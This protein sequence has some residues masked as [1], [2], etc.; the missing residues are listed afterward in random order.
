MLKH[1][2][3][4]S[5][6]A[7]LA[8]WSAAAMVVVVIAVTSFTLWVLRSDMT[9][10]VADV[11]STLSESI[12]R[13]VDARVADRRLALQQAASVLDPAMIAKPDELREHF[14]SRPVVQGLFET[15]IVVD[16][17]GRITFDTPSFTGR[18]GRSVADRPYFK[19]LMAT[20]RPVVSDPLSGRATGE[21]SIVFA[22]PIRTATGETVGFLGGVMYLTR[23]NFLSDLANVK[24][25]KTGYVSVIV[26][27]DPPVIMMHG[28]KDRIMTPVPPP[29]S[30]PLVYRALAGD[31]GSFEGTNSVGL[32]AI[33]SFRLL[34][35]VPWL[36]TTA[37]PLAEA[38]EQ[39]RGSERQV[40]ALGLG[41]M[42]LAGIGIWVLVE[43]LL[44][45]LD[46]LRAAMVQSRDRSEPV[47]VDVRDE[48]REVYEVVEAYNT[49]MAH[50]HE[51]RAAV[52]QSEQRL[53]TI[54]DNLPVLIS[55][56]DAD[57]RM[58]FA[59]ETY[60][61]WSDVD[62]V[63]AIGRRIAD[64]VAPELY[65]QR[66]D[67]LRAALSGQRVEFDLV[68][69]ARGARRHLHTVYVPDVRED[70]R[71]AGLY[72]LSTDVT[73]LKDVE[74]KLNA[75]ARVD[76]LTGLPNRRAFD[77]RLQASVAR[78]R[79]TRQRLALLFLDV[80]HFKEINDTRGHG[81][82]DEVLCEFA[83][84]LLTCVRQTDTV[85]RLA[86]DE[87]V[88]ILEGLKDLEEASAIAEK[89]GLLM[90]LP[91]HVGNEI[92]RVTTSIGV[93][94]VDDPRIQADDIMAKADGALYR[95]KRN[96]RNTFAVST[97]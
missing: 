21:A 43:R 40:I 55:Y 27:G 24:V 74:T 9:R 8:F 32:D 2:K 87:F 76:P 60:R 75:L 6:K 96:G 33:Y 93:A 63:A 95:A 44:A 57:E 49:L 7:K 72:A 52:Q 64:V 67:A 28:H 11:Q 80:D 41:L 86:G 48:T 84:R 71:V 56:V 15:L 37:Y 1:Y 90:R 42:V 79:R 31:E 14:A 47:V 25:G 38:R 51:A 3:R 68:S 20:G 85:A 23:P 53:R 78:H 82:G 88:I 92:R 39:L 26:K 91:F 18:S 12:A 89:I 65:E 13:E 97:F 29:A 46:H 36:L 19:E 66:R 69:T 4:R 34:K 35:N 62:P 54:A 30:S 10:N 83:R 16:R 50:T 61:A 59:N 58:Q 17:E 22:A 77:E 94:Y 5:L 70:G 73:A 81:T 45:P